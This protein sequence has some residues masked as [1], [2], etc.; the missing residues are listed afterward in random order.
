MKSIEQQKRL[1]SKTQ[2]LGKKLK[3]YIRKQ[4]RRKLFYGGA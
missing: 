1:K 4:G 2:G 3:T